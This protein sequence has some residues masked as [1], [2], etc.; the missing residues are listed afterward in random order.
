MGSPGNSENQGLVPRSLEQIFE[1]RQSLQCQGWKYELQVNTN[2]FAT[3]MLGKR[4]I[5]TSVITYKGL[6]NE[7]DDYGS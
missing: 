3:S 2:P 6:G 5:F 7:N 4:K 1:T